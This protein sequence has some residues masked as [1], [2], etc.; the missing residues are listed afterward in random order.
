MGWLHLWDTVAERADMRA[1]KIDAK[2]KC[3]VA[4]DV[5]SIDDCYAALS[6]DGCS[7]DCFDVVR[8]GSNN[9]Y[10]DDDGMGKWNYGFEI[11]GMQFVGNGVLVGPVDSEGN[12]TPCL[13]D[14][15]FVRWLI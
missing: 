5:H 9:I 4:I 11:L 7:C 2:N 13:L 15:V 1:L 10:V 3:V 14:D 8:C 6:S 12:D